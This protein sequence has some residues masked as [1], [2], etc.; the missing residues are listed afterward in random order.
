MA[1]STEARKTLRE[2]DKELAAASVE[3]GQTLEW[4]TAE[5]S[6]LSLISATI[7]RK[8]DIANA[9]AK[10]ESPSARVALSAE[11]RLLEAAQARLLKQI[12]TEAPVSAT[13]ATPLSAASAKASRAGA[14]GARS[15]W[16]RASG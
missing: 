15:R 14:K 8:V 7:D 10:A 12:S 16:N 6:I 1:R 5:R 4:S 3:L 11:L 2:L 9:Y 13:A